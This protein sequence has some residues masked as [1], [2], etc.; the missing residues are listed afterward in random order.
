MDCSTVK[1]GVEC[2]F[3]TKKGCAFNGGTCH[4]AVEACDGCSRTSEYSSGWFCTACPDPSSKWKNGR[5]NLATHVKD[6]VKSETSKINPLKAS[7]RN[8]H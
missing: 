3:M 2:V 1:S 6:A 7:K 4:P 8:A 5:C